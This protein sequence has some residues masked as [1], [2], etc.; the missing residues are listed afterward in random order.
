MSSRSRPEQSRAQA[1]TAGQAPAHRATP[2]YPSLR[3]PSRRPECSPE[4][5]P[6]DTVGQI[7]DRCGEIGRIIPLLDYPEVVEDQQ[8]GAARTVGQD[9]GGVRLM[10]GQ[11]Y[12]AGGA[13]AEPGPIRDRPAALRPSQ[14][15]VKI[16]RP[17][18]LPAPALVA[19]PAEPRDVVGDRTQDVGPVSPDVAAAIAVE[20]DCVAEEGRRHELALA[21]RAGPGSAHR[22]GTHVALV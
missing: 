17:N 9:Q 22:I 18:D 13:H 15:L 6:I 1:P 4:L 11:R 20:I 2:P 5:P 14:A 8:R 16:A 21:H 10:P 3:S 19:M 12:R 7:A